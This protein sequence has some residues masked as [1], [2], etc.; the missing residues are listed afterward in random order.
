MFQLLCANVALNDCVNI[1]THQ[2]AVGSE[3]GRVI[4]PLLDLTAKNNF[5]GLSLRDVTVSE[6]MPIAAESVPIVTIDELKLDACHFL[7]I[8][9]EGMEC[10]VLRG[11]LETIDRHRPGIYVEND[12]RE[13]SRELIALLLG[14]RYRLYCHLTPLSIVAKNKFQGL[15][16]MNMLCVPA[17]IQLVVSGL[18][19]VASVEDWWQ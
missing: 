11:A 3:I 5:G 17:E 1:V 6:S 13:R 14:R 16:S 10:E 4:V 7:K 2:A 12:R 15:S 19:E 9:V 8:D 18:R